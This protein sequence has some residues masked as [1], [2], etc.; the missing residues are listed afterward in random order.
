[1][2]VLPLT[3]L[4]TCSYWEEPGAFFHEQPHF[5]LFR[6]EAIEACAGVPL[7]GLSVARLE[8]YHACTIASQQ[9]LVCQ[10]TGQFAVWGEKRASGNSEPA[11]A[12][13]GPR[14]PHAVF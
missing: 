11:S 10:I 6:V 4:Q 5:K 13:D 3:C 9:V 12:F 2:D 7:Q 8:A 1:M 14:F